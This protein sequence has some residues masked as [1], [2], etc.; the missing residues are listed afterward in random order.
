MIWPRALQTATTGC[1]VYSTAPDGAVAYNKQQSDS[2]A[3]L[4]MVLQ[5]HQIK[6]F[7]SG[8][9]YRTGWSSLTQHGFS[10]GE[11]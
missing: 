1:N 9:H 6:S 2:V 8:R 10:S 4:T 3:F 5:R 11:H 7:I